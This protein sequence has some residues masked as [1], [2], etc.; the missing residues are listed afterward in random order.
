M[1]PVEIEALYF[2]L[3]KATLQVRQSVPNNI[4]LIEIGF[5]PIRA[6]I[7]CRQLK[8]FRR[9]K[10][11]LDNQGRRKEVHDKCN[12]DVTAYVKHY[13]DLD[14]KYQTGA[15][16]KTEFVKKIRD[17]I[18]RKAQN[19]SNYKHYIYLKVNPTL[20]P[21]PFLDVQNTHVINI[22]KFRLGSHKFPIE[23]G[24]WRRI[25]RDQRLCQLCEVLGDEYHIMFECPIINRDNL[26]LPPSLHELW[27]SNNLFVLFEKITSDRFALAHNKRVYYFLL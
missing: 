25:P 8:Y 4:V 3:I 22:T 11:S 14:A 19:N 6:I 7:Y 15:D 16:I 17:D 24:R 9:F 13:N 1:F 20:T 26:A 2:K 21:S 12:E 27:N 18:M 23:T 5:L 10:N